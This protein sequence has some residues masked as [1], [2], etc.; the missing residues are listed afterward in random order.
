MY[1][2][3][4]KQT[5]AVLI[6]VAFIIGLAVAAYLLY[7]LNPERLRAEQDKKAMITLALAK[8]AIIS[9]SVSRTAL[10][11][12]PGEMPWPDYFGATETPNF[13]YD[14]DTDGGCLNATKITTNGLP[15][16]N[17]GKNMRCLGRLPWRTIGMSISEPTQNDPVGNMP[18]YAVSA[19]LIDSTCLKEL[20]SSILN[21]IYTSY[22]CAGTTLPH[23]WLTVKDSSGNVINKRVA[24]VLMMPSSPL[25]SQSRPTTPLNLV[26]NYLDKIT[27]P[28]GCPAPCKPGVYSN[29]DLD[30]E[31][32]ISD[33]ASTANQ[34][35]DQIIYITIDELM[36][37]VERR[38]TQ[39]AAVQ[40]KKYYINS[41][42]SAANRFYPY[43]ASLGDANNGC[44]ENKYSGL[45][46]YAASCSSNSDC[47][48]SFFKTPQVEFSNSCIGDYTASSG[49][50]TFAGT[51]CACTGAGS[52]T[53]NPT[54]KN[55]V[56]IDE[57]TLR[58][59]T[60]DN[61]GRC[62]SNIAGKYTF[63]YLPPSPDN[64]VTNNACVVTAA[65]IITCTG[66]GSFSVTNCNHPNK[67]LASLPA[68]FTD[69]RWQDYIYYAISKNNSASAPAPIDPAA[70][71]T[72]GSRVNVQALV[73]ASGSRLPSTEAQPL[74]GQSRP[75]TNITDYLDSL[76]NTANPSNNTIFDSTS[77]M[78][79]SNY[80]DQPLIV[81]P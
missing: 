58:N 81:A 10:G 55:S 66:Q 45:M 51:T 38:A 12:R 21:Q 62:I 25:S 67:T 41:S 69:N 75:S 39:E 47:S 31:F 44:V 17:S 77:K 80:N 74:S 73:V 22:V 27:V 9:Y 78:K 18:W 53:R 11:E 65:N 37:A 16:I 30:N 36:R 50:C 8:E 76:V 72:V 19:N 3:K 68:W 15:Q 43:A 40:L 60:C 46:P 2:L 61:N 34:A 4:F 57:D 33:Q 32:I 14:G 79:S 64:T 29:A 28:V 59:F 56:C 70:Y 7:A 1:K 20:N 48:S 13:N 23:P 49:A 42:V 24:I 52:C 5:G 54:K 71:L 6:L 63:T 26:A 35:N